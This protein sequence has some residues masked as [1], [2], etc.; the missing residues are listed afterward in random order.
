MAD[1]RDVAVWSNHAVEQW[2]ENKL[3]HNPDPNGII[4]QW[5]NRFLEPNAKVLDF[6]CGGALW[7]RTFLG[8]DYHGSDQNENMVKHAHMRFPD[9]LDKIMVN[10]WDNLS[11]AD[12]TFDA[13]FTSAVLQHNRHPDKEKAVK[14]I[15]RVLKPGGY[16]IATEN[17][18]QKISGNWIHTFPQAFEW[19]EAMDDGYSFTE[20]G[21]ENFMSRFDLALVE[22]NGKSEYLFQKK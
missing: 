20:V 8:F 19:H 21:W 2:E 6:G 4:A 15:V 12:E 16:Y 5:L 3:G 10:Q 11:Y 14:E 9:L 18:F 17:T 13:V 22:Y 7:R 1:G